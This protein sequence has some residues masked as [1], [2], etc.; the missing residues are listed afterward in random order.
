MYIQGSGDATNLATFIP[1]SCSVPESYRVD[2][3][4][5]QLIGVA[6]LTQH[7]TCV[8]GHTCSFSKLLG[9]HLSSTDHV[10]IMDTCAGVTLLERWP[11]GGAMT[12]SASGGAANTA[13]A[14]VTAQGG[15]YRLCWCASGQACSLSEDSSI[16]FGQL[17]LV[18]P[19]PLFQDRTCVSGKTCQVDGVEGQDLSSRDRVMVL[20][21]CGAGGS[22]LGRSA[23]FDAHSS[24]VVVTL[25][26]FVVT[27]PGGQYRLC[28]CSDTGEA[29]VATGGLCGGDVVS[30]FRVDLGR[31]TLVG[32]YLAHQQTCVSGNICSLAELLGHH[33]AGTDSILVLDTCQTSAGVVPRFGSGGML[34]VASP[35]LDVVSAAG[36]QYRLCW[37]A[38]PGDGS[39][40]NPC[41]TGENFWTDAGSLSLMGP[42]PLAQD[43]TCISGRT[44]SFDVSGHELSA[45]DRVLLLSTCGTYLASKR[46]EVAAPLTPYNVLETVVTATATWSVSATAGGG[47][48][49]L[50]WCHTGVRSCQ[51][52]DDF[53][54]DLGQVTFIGVSSLAQDRTC[55][56]G[57]T[58]HIDAVVG[59]DLHSGDRILVL[60]TCGIRAAP[61]RLA[62][63]GEYVDPDVSRA[64]LSWGTVLALIAIIAIIA[65]TAITAIMKLQLYQL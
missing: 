21:T 16:D 13:A 64:A 20:D 33:L 35:H 6:P 43:Q 2:V 34:T 36:G 55:V 23:V 56:A 22:I 48:Y 7:R 12:I 49:R 46:F 38:T 39:A 40:V 63:Y 25:G 9:R 50:C 17:T 4:E 19:R 42:S 41:A 60:D 45:L 30:E 14:P 1:L 51:N 26:S 44:C 11:H 32:P 8:A 53:V 10:T 15:V 29:E 58:C 28:W 65:V 54:T 27:T 47:Q 61:P 18:G 5:L 62:G 31:L 59:Q 3:G 57:Q 37:C 24:G 52:G